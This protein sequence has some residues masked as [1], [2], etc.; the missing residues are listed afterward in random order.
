MA[1]AKKNKKPWKTGA[2]SWHIT[3]LKQSILE[4]FDIYGSALLKTTLVKYT[5]LFE[6]FQLGSFSNKQRQ[7]DS[8]LFLPVETPTD[9]VIKPT[10]QPG[11]DVIKLFCP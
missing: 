3:H 6:Q 11:A 4:T 9:Y 1:T 5:S 10:G 7:V 2:F 8:K